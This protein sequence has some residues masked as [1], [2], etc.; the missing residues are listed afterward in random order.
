M[1]IIEIANNTVA[2]LDKI[3]SIA[4]AIISAAA[5]IYKMRR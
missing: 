4:L 3:A 2:N 1:L 5:I